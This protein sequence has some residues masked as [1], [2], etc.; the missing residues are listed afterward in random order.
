MLLRVQELTRDAVGFVAITR[1]RG[2]VRVSPFDAGTIQVVL[3]RRDR[4]PEPMI[5]TLFES[6]ALPATAG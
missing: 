4:E 2:P 6:P 5:A 1:N 3:E